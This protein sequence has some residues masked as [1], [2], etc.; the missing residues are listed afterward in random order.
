M[1]I[2]RYATPEEIESIRSKADLATGG[3]V[4]T[5]GGK[6]FAV[7][8]NVVEL[9]PVIFAEDTSNS[10]KLF[11]V[12]ALETFLR[13]TG[14]PAYYFNIHAEDEKWLEIAKKNGAEALSTAPEIRLKKTLLP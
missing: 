6:E 14:T 1:D 10:R 8:R 4:V 11:F 12:Q 7:I 3:S 2:I 5:F 13:L 9:D